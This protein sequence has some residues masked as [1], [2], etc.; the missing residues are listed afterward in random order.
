[1]RALK[2]LAAAIDWLNERIGRGAAYLAVALVVVQFIV[3]VMRYVFGLGS[4]GMQESIVYM[5]GVL[6]MAAAAYTLL[7]NAHVRVDIFY[8]EAAPKKKAT[9]DLIGTVVLLWP[10][11]WLIWSTAFPYVELSWAVKEGSRE[12][13]G[14]HAI[15]LLKSV[16]LVFA[17]LLALQGISTVIH[18]VAVLRGDEMPSPEERGLV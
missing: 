17:A 8:R 9:I 6:F 3:V 12:T 7:H 5:H 14:I 4:V 1:M 11:C 18:A 13:S 16:I 10:I 15:Y 2:R